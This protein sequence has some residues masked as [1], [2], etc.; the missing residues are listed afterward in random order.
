[1]STDNGYNK[2]DVEDS[3]QVITYLENLRRSQLRIIK[4]EKEYL[5]EYGEMMDDE[6]RQSYV[7]T[8]TGFSRNLKEVEQLINV[9][10]P[11]LTPQ[12]INELAN[13][14]LDLPLLRTRE[15]MEILIKALPKSVRFDFSGPIVGVPYGWVVENIIK[16]CL[17]VSGE[18]INLINILAVFDKETVQFQ[19]LKEYLSA[20]QMID[21]KTSGNGLE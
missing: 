5:A 4:A 6:T 10:N 20:S 2:N 17:H 3:S 9:A 21:A 1:M 11:N 8:I 16:A 13:L 7:D 12:Q 19:K 18:F 15:G 14:I